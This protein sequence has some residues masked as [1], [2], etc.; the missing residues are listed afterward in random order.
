MHGKKRK[1]L[2]RQRKRFAEM[3]HLVCAP[4]TIPSNISFAINDFLALE[5]AGWKG[6]RTSTSS[7]A[8]AT[9]SAAGIV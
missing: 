4:D 6:R 3:G 9:L 8:R 1:E 5:A 7:A 2:R